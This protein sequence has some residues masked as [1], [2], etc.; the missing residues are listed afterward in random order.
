MMNIK[1]LIERLPKKQYDIVLKIWLNTYRKYTNAKDKIKLAQFKKPTYK[2]LKL[3]NI[4]YK[5]LIDPTNG[6]VDNYIYLNNFY[7]KNI[8]LLIKKILRKKDVFVDVGANIGQH[9]IFAAKVVGLKGEVHSF[10]PIKKLQE[11]IKKSINANKLKNMTL[12]PYAC[13]NTTKEQ[14]INI[15]PHN[16]GGSSLKKNKSEQKEKIKIIPLDTKI[17]NANLVKIDVEGYEYNVLLGMK[18]LSQKE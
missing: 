10:E 17:T 15:L 2:K 6:H 3:D 16:I 12:H 18:A 8:L 1:N 7:E 9:S 14:T 5:I 13:G 4:S 11:Q